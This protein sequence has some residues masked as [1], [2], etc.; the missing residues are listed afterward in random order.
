M[1]AFIMAT[2]EFPTLYWGG[3]IVWVDLVNAG[4]A[5]TDDNSHKRFD[6]VEAVKSINGGNSDLQPELMDLLRRYPSE[7]AVVDSLVEY[8]TRNKE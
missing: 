7:Q 5:G 3:E 4:K 8:I 2:V 6:L 1:L